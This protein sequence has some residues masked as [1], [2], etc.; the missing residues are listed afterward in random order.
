VHLIGRLIDNLF[1]PSQ[2]D[3]FYTY[4]RKSNVWEA[5]DFLEAYTTIPEIAAIIDMKARATSNGILKEVNKDG[6]DTSTPRGQQL[7]ALLSRP[8]WLQS[9]KEFIIQTKTLREIFGNEY[10][11][12]TTPLGFGSSLEKTKALYTIPHNIVKVKYD[13]QVPYFL[14]DKA[15]KLKY[16]VKKA[17]DWVEYDQDRFIHFNDNRAAIKSST[18]ENLILG[19][20][21]MKANECIINNIK[22]AYESR[23]MIVKH[24]GANGAWVNSSKDMAGAK[25]LSKPDKQEIQKEMM[26]YGTMADQHTDIITNSELKWVQRGVLNPIHLGLFEEIRSGFDKLLDAYGVPAEI[27]VR[28]EGS[29][30]ENQKEAEKALYTRT[31][32]PEANEWIGGIVSEFDLTTNIVFDYMHLPAFQEDLK[33]RGESLSVTISALSAA[34]QDQAIDIETYKKELEKFNI[35]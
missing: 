8:N 26:S 32:I 5:V 4:S 14:N 31:V 1:N 22:A 35:N 16:K 2:K 18:D 27:F 21:R 13:S 12:K 10:I 25:P 20:S 19:E 15:P 29:T 7:I 24:R 23:G 9:G 17:H 3:W 30:Y 11:F 34:F 6:K 33:Q 28:A